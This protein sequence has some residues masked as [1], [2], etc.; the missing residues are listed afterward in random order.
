MIKRPVTELSDPITFTIANTASVSDGLYLEGRIPVALG[1]PAA[2]TAAGIT[3]QVSL[4]RMASWLDLYGLDGLE[5]TIATPAV[6]CCYALA[7]EQ[8]LG[9]THLR[10][11]SGDSAGPIAQG[12]ERIL[13]LMAAKPAS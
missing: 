7:A 13:T 11:R 1:L 9:A 5:V 10:I 3:F 6:D 2:W 4:D 8:F 12:A